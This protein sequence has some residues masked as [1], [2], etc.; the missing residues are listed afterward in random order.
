M[1]ARQVSGAPTWPNASVNKAI[2]AQ[3]GTTRVEV[4][5][6]PERLYVD[7]K[8]TN[9]ADGQNLLLPTGVQVVHHGSEYDITS[10]SGDAVRATLYGVLIDATVGLGKTPAPTRGLLGTPGASAQELVAANAQC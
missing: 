1:H 2:V 10:A 6:E 4:Y 8:P 3:M 7:G 9:L 5:V